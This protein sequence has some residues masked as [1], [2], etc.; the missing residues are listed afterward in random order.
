MNK[1]RNS[2]YF[3]RRAKK[4]VKKS[5]SL[6]GELQMLNKQ[7]IENS[8]LGTDLDDNIFKIRLASES[9]GKGKSGGFRV[10][11]YLLEETEE[12]NI[13]H[14]ITIYDKA[15]IADIPKNVL[16]EIIEDVLGEESEET[17]ME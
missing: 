2:G 12:D 4:L 7:L 1:I 3:G 11:T 9:K 6:A 15:E 13:I 10:I 17:E 5:R 16:K 8:R 14:L